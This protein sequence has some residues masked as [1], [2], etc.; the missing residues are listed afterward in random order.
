M[1]RTPRQLL[2]EAEARALALVDRGYMGAACSNL[3][4]AVASDLEISRAAEDLV[5]TFDA[6]SH[7][8][9]RA[10]DHEQLKTLIKKFA[11]KIRSRLNPQE[12]LL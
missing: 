7:R 9:M 8:H 2:D 4:G 5:G 1:K 10:M 3:L 11:A 12:E 6:E